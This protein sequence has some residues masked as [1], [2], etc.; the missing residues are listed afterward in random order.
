MRIRSVWW[1]VWAWAAVWTGAR[2]PGGGG[3]WHYF[4][5]GSRL[6]FGDDPGQGLHLYAAHPDL[7]IGPVAFLAATPL[8]LLGASTGRLAAI[9]AMSATG[10]LVLY[11]LW[12]LVPEPGRRPSRLLA[13]GAVFLPVWAELVTHA[14]HLDDVLALIFAVAA[15]HAVRSGHPVAAGLLVA[16][17]ADAKP[18]AA[19][20]APLVLAVAGRARWRAGA[21]WAGG[22]AAAWLPFLLYDGRTLTAAG[23]TIPTATSSGLRALG[24]AYART[25]AW[26]RPAQLVLGCLLGTAAVARGRWP[27]VILAGTAARILL[28]PEVYSYYT[29]GILLGA[30][31]YDLAV[32]DGRWPW[33]TTGGLVSLY[34]ARLVAHVAPISLHVLGLLRVGYVIAVIA[35]VL[36]PRR[37]EGQTPAVAGDSESRSSATIRRST[38]NVRNGMTPA[39][40]ISTTL[41]RGQRTR[42]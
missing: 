26:D 8:R 18:W 32:A 11:A 39:R 13:A 31:A 1:W 9:A 24:F 15:L 37:T 40:T 30:L 20:F 42:R 4:A 27:A 23:F 21:A 2:L 3:S 41:L 34:V 29:A 10:P 35:V 19:A 38:Q 6:L 36:L 22:L 17:S 5:Q 7:Q 12:R 28:D 33:L 16:A 14:G 25:P